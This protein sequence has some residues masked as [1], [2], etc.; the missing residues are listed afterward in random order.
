MNKNYKAIFIFMIFMTF[1]SQINSS[2]TFAPS[3]GN[4][5]LHEAVRNNNY[6]DVAKLLKKGAQVNCRNNGLKTPLHIA[7]YEGNCELIRL[8]LAAGADVNAQDWYGCTPLYHAVESELSSCEMITILL[9][10]GAD[11]TIPTY[12]KYHKT[13]LSIVYRSKNPYEVLTLLF[14]KGVQV[15]SYD[16]SGFGSN[17]LATFIQGHLCPEDG[18][19]INNFYEIIKLLINHGAHINN[20]SAINVINMNKDNKILQL[21]LDTKNIDI[22][23]QNDLRGLTLLHYAIIDN[24]YD[25]IILLLHAGARTDI[26][27]RDGL[28]PLYYAD[29]QVMYN[30]LRSF[31]QFVVTDAND[32]FDKH[33]AYK[34]NLEIKTDEEG[35]TLL[36]HAVLADD[37]YEVQ[38]LINLGSNVNKH[39]KKFGCT[40]LHY[41]V[42]RA[43]FWMC[44]LLIEAGADVNSKDDHGLTPLH[45]TTHNRLDS[46]HDEEKFSYFP[47]GGLSE[48]CLLL[49]QAGAHVNHKDYTGKTSLHYAALYNTCTVAKLLIEFGADFNDKDN[50]GLTPVHCADY[51]DYLN[52]YSQDQEVMAILIAAGADVNS[53]DNH[54]LSPLLY[55]L[56][57]EKYGSLRLWNRIHDM[58]LLLLDAGADCNNIDNYGH[59]LLN[60]AVYNNNL[61]RALFL[62]EHGADMNRLDL[63]GKIPLDYAKS[64]EMKDLFSQFKKKKN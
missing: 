55:V 18:R 61:D 21:L 59:S 2:F 25:R 45:Y 10:N 51:H 46:L 20:S 1:V 23:I 30:F 31:P 24:A 36:H 15:T 37:E 27:D 49:L 42:D 29:T 41:A 54:G 33:I 39:D 12:N 13:P 40:P 32:T 48:I 35:R 64:K 17:V 52:L 7:V 3:G 11:Y 63:Y 4:T 9:D 34:N 19:L 62:L 26:L 22:N 5:P 6:K 44:K 53:K 8:L 58:A 50:E 43:S 14:D 57:S 56:Y 28:S 38:R 16:N 47:C 60:Y